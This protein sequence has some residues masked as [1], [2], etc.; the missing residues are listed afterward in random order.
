MKVLFVGIGSIGTRHLKNLSSIA[1]KD[2]IHLVVH[3][4]RSRL[5]PLSEEVENLIDKQITSL[6]EDD[7]DIAF[8]TNPTNL[9]Y[10]ILKDLK[11]KAKFFF[12]E[13]PIFENCS[14]NL[15]DLNLNE[16]NAYIAC[17]MRY[18]KTYETLKDILKDEKVYSA[19]I[20]C[21]SYLP[22][23]RKNIDYRK[24]YSAIKAMG[25][26][27]TIDL[28]HELDYMSDLFGFP[29]ESYNF[30]G[31]Y[32]HLEID[33]DDLSVYIARYKDKLIEVHLDYIGRVPKRT[34]EAFTK[35]GT[36]VAEFNK[37]SV[38]LP[39]LEEINCNEDA[40]DRFI[41]EMTYFLNLV[42]K[43]VENKNP[44]KNAYKV[45]ALTLGE[46]LNI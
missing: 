14:Y 11:N 13:K 3:A 22:D 17:P 42:N 15:D 8:I 46:E 10:P 24:N 7:Y 27:V 43:K 28:I 29:L 41:K 31:Q 4:L 19:R 26:G 20:I 2:G 6:E 12:I 44:P 40:N 25:G 45:L 39:S 21:S 38:T 16:N 18:T 37:G 9:H 36:I 32:S 34:L 33:S 1:K 5:S 30:K 35:D 23:W